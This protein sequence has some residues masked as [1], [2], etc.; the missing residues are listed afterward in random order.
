MAGET[1]GFEGM[2]DGTI[3][4]KDGVNLLDKVAENSS[5]PAD[6]QANQPPADNQP[7]NQEPDYRAKFKELYNVE[8]DELPS[9][10][11]RASKADQYKAQAEADPFDGDTESKAIFDLKKKGIP[12]EIALRYLSMDLSKLSPK[13]KMVLSLQLAKPT[14]KREDIEF[15][16]NKKYG[17]GEFAPKNDEDVPDETQ[18]LRDIEFEVAGQDGIDAKLAQQKEDLLKV[19][20]KP[21][22]QVVKEQTEEALKTDWDKQ[23]PALKTKA[24]A[25]EVKL[26]GVA[27]F[28][29]DLDLSDDDVKAISDNWIKSGHGPTDAN[30]QVAEKILREAA[31]GRNVDKIVSKAV[32]AATGKLEEDVYDELHHTSL[33]NPAPTGD[34]PKSGMDELKEAAARHKASRNK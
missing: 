13:E 9:I 25:Y 28:K 14:I 34:L 6:N 1:T 20:A 30:L 26:K 16:V 29:V 31:L 17:L 11:D 23:L 18:G 22:S 7:A 21:R 4:A 15:Q 10:M 12:A 24:T 5:A 19:A 32:Q 27:P 33:K 3:I 8:P 2:K